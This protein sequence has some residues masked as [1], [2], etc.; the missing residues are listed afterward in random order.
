MRLQQE[1]VLGIGGWRVAAGC[2]TDPEV[3][4]FNEGHAAFAML[5]RAAASWPSSGQSLRG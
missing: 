5:E 4:H 3:C 1:I 2:W